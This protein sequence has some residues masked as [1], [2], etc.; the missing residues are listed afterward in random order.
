[1]KRELSSTKLKK[2]E[3]GG[4]FYAT[5]TWSSLE[6][7]DEGWIGPSPTKIMQQLHNQNLY[8]SKLTL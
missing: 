8:F 7:G 4:V 3:V 5:G 2:L 1:M 6:V